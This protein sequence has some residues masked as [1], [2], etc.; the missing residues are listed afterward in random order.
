[1]S[2]NPVQSVGGGGATVAAFG[3]KRLLLC[4]LSRNAVG[5]NPAKSIYIAF[6]IFFFFSFEIESERLEMR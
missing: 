1:M 2:P 3:R 4:A 5:L 6:L